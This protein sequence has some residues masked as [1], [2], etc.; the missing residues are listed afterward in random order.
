[1]RTTNLEGI[2]ELLEGAK[3]IV[4]VTHWSP[5]GDAIGSSLGLKNF[6]NATI[7]ANVTV[8][9]PNSYPS[10]L[11]WMKGNND[12]LLHTEHPEEVAE[13]VHEADVIFC[14]DFNHLGRINDLGLEVEKSSARKCIIDH[15]PQPGDFAEFILHDVKSSSTCELIY[16]F[17]EY[18]NGVSTIEKEIAS[19]LYAGI[20][21]DTGSFRFPSTSAK[22]HKVI[23]QLIEAGVDNSEI[24]NRVHDNCTE[25]KLR[26]LGF[27]LSEKIKVFKDSGTAYFALSSEELD[28]FNYQ[29]GDTEGVVNYALSIAGIYFAAFI[30]ERDG[31]VK[32]SFRSKGE[33]NVNEFA[34]EHFSGGGHK[35][36]AGGVSNVSLEETTAKFESLIPK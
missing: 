18:L 8:V 29:K 28:R 5:D 32:M 19:C 14:L 33:F 30:V 23:A 17:I 2:Q 22:T 12:V 9:V 35:N 36:A 15:H 16:D 27:C 6:F 4:I 24:Y 34:R 26:L 25:D 13:V 31:V 20:M 1:M 3:K 11:H 7:N 21:T 10:F